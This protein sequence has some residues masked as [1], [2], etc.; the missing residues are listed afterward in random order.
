M[1]ARQRVSFCRWPSHNKEVVYEVYQSLCVP[2][3]LPSK[4]HNTSSRAYTSE[5]GATAAMLRVPPNAAQCRAMQIDAA[6]CCPMQRNVAQCRAM[7]RNA[8]QCRATQ[9]RALAD[10]CRPVP[11]NT[12]TST[13][14][15]RAI[16]RNTEYSPLFGLSLDPRNAAQGSAMM[17]Q[18][19][20]SRTTTYW[21][22]TGLH[23][24]RYILPR[25]VSRAEFEHLR[26]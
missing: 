2:H 25:F 15:L 16:P 20:S 12:S 26:N 19:V 22:I 11:L 4:L 7:Q 9:R 17:V 13:S 24:I 8:A 3:G 21:Q 23:C 1:K 10:R 18:L 6:Q 5:T 14:R